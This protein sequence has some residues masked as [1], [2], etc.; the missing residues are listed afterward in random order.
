MRRLRSGGVISYAGKT[1]RWSS[2]NPKQTEVTL[3]AGKT[4][5]AYVEMLRARQQAFNDR[6]DH[7]EKYYRDLERWAEGEAEAFAALPEV[8][9]ANARREL[10][11]ADAC[12]KEAAEFWLR[13]ARD[14][15]YKKGIP[16]G[17]FVARPSEYPPAKSVSDGI[18][19]RYRSSC[20]SVDQTWERL[21]KAREA[22]TALGPDVSATCAAPAPDSQ[23]EPFALEMAT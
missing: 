16:A 9:E 23:E 15:C 7:V 19:R 20:N 6:A 8:A 1:S 14:A 2:G 5:R 3:T 12:F 18:L 4:D 17:P 21:G 11:E 10:A 13:A 22:V